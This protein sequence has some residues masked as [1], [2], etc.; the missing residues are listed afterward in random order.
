M[1]T[2]ARVVDNNNWCANRKLLVYVGASG[3]RVVSLNRSSGTA[4]AAVALTDERLRRR[5][6]WLTR[7]RVRFSAIKF[8]V[9][10]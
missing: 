4:A 5:R 7:F 9:M 6:R 8:R 2:Y 10:K 1:M 3:S